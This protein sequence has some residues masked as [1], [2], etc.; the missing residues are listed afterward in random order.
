[1]PR[2]L[3]DGFEQH[4]KTDFNA[5]LG[6]FDAGVI[7]FD[8]N[9]LLNVLRYSPTARRELLDAIKSVA[10][11]CIVPHQIALEYNRNR[12]Q[13]VAD[14]R[15]EL[16]DLA[17]K[18]SNVRTSGRTITNTLR[19][20]RMIPSE[21][22]EP[23]EKSV[24]QFFEALDEAHTEALEQYDLDP[25]TITGKIDEWTEELNEALSG[26]VAEPPSAE[27]R[28]QD[29]EE[30]ERRVA[31]RVAPGF[32]DSPNGDYLW[33]AE[34]LRADETTG[35]DI[36]IV[37]DDAAKGDW[38]FEERGMTLGPH[39]ILVRDAEAA[40]IAS[41]TL[42][43]TFEFLRLV[44]ARGASPVS[45]AT[46]AESEQTASHNSEPWTLDAYLQLLESLRGDGYEDRVKVIRSAGQNNGEITRGDLYRIA[47]ISEEE[48]SLRQFATPANR[49]R[50]SISLEMLDSGQ[51][52]SEPLGAFYDGPG[53]AI[54]YR[55]PTE[56]VEFEHVLGFLNDAALSRVNPTRISDAR[57]PSSIT[58]S[59]DK[60]LVSPIS[61][62]N[63]AI[64]NRIISFLGQELRNQ[65]RE[66]G[67]GDLP[68]DEP[69]SLEP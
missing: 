3:V 52:L 22:L 26:R 56:F 36:F 15:K 68:G 20:R 16:D 23:L 53:K 48:R 44:E 18:I 62:K 25:N 64:E 10:N 2:N 32:K 19:T 45:D 34:T 41:L 12:V 58:R 50:R 66:T 31:E 17:D 42:L 46:I 29:E 4:F 69:R 61:A 59:I 9:V 60:H 57:F 13:V 37:S 28:R 5:A 43:T 63:P 47:Q 6:K 35:R 55:V 67:G 7:V 40:G 11:R 8:T 14:R 49:H 38:R 1:M 51:E 39:E 21:N 30:A 65:A 24:S 27:E 33:W 54:G